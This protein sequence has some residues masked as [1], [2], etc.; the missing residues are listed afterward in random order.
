MS[1]ASEFPKWAVRA[2]AANRK[3]Q[4]HTQWAETR[5]RQWSFQ[6]DLKK[7]KEYADQKKKKEFRFLFDFAADPFWNS[8]RLVASSETST[9]PCVSTTY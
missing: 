8:A 6:G 7:K 3:T 4:T 5:R 1:S 2:M 9:A